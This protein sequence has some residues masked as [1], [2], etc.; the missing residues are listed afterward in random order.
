VSAETEALKKKEASDK[1]DP[2]TAKGLSY[3]SQGEKEKL[4][5]E[6]RANNIRMGIPNRVDALANF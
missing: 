5:R 3:L 1:V 4:I 6:K 2:L